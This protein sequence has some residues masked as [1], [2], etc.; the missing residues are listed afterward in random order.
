M[1][2]NTEPEP[3]PDVTQPS[4]TSTPTNGRKALAW[5]SSDTPVKNPFEGAP[6]PDPFDGEDPFGETPKRAIIEVE[7]P[8]P[9]LS[10]Q[11]TNLILKEFLA[12]I[13]TSCLELHPSLVWY[14]PFYIADQDLAQYTREEA[15]EILR[16]VSKLNPEQIQAVIESE[17]DLNIRAL[18][19]TGKTSLL[20]AAISYLL[21]IGIPIDQIAISSHTVS[22]AGEIQSR[23]MPTLETLFPKTYEFYKT[24]SMT[25]GTIHAIAY[26]EM[27][28]HKHPKARW[29]ILDEGHQI[30][31]WKE[32]VLFAYPE[33]A[34]AEIEGP[35]L[36]EL[37]M[38]DRVRGYDIAETQVP[39]VLQLI[40]GSAEL[41]K[42][43]DVYRKIKEAR[44]LL[45]YTDLL[46]E[47]APIIIHPG[48]ANKWR[49]FFVDEFQDTNPL[50]KFLLKL[51]KEQN[52]KLV[53]CGDTRQSI[54]SFTGSD[55]TSHEPFFKE[56]GIKETFLET[57]YR[58]SR[59][60]IGLANAILQSMSPSEEA[61]LRAHAGAPH[62]E[63]A[64]L[65]FTRSYKDNRKFL[66]EK[67]LE[68]MRKKEAEISCNEAIR[69][70]D[71][72]KDEERGQQ[73]VAVLYRTNAQ[74]GVLEEIMSG[75]NSKR[76]AEGKS[77]IPYTRKDFRRTALRN[78]TEREVLMILQ[79]WSDPT[80]C[81]WEDL[82]QTPYFVGIGEVTARTIKRKADQNKPQ[83]LE[84]AAIIFEGELTKRN[85]E[86][87]DTFFQAWEKACDGQ[88]HKEPD[89]EAAAI[90]LEE[91]IL[92]MS[93]KKAATAGSKKEVEDT[94]R[95]SYE[96]G[97][98]ERVKIKQAEGKSLAAIISEISEENE[99]TIANQNNANR[100]LSL[101][102]NN[103]QIVEKE[104]GLVFS[105]IHLAKGR[106]YDGVVIHQMSRGSLPHF[107]ALRFYDN[108]RNEL[109]KRF[110]K[111]ASFPS[112]Q[113]AGENPTSAD[114]P[115][116]RR[117]GVVFS[118][119]RNEID[120]WEDLNN[121]IEE[122]KRLLYV[123]VTRAKKLLSITTADYEYGFL[124]TDV[125]EKLKGNYSFAE[126][127]SKKAG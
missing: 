10:D 89:A 88:T 122:E 37:R 68:I 2:E 22:A 61:R 20:S 72:L 23:V 116:I 84:D 80:Q 5:N 54:N 16:T 66:S 87:M 55:P 105:T 29:T 108:P 92:S 83:C 120:A 93:T 85:V 115:E 114:L 107:N 102:G 15:I 6:S 78:K 124:P 119:P 96:A 30:R 74:G 82:L 104:E 121:P 36:D 126:K 34:G 75:I 32:A 60:V 12:E 58:C 125:W 1:T 94:Q 91:W 17:N 33:K 9:F 11:E 70:Y 112:L 64:N 44:K 48:Y 50:Q 41:P 43:A 123:A 79:A 97:I 45:D 117:F 99:K 63:P 24:S 53:V 7:A 73:T 106:E 14:E 19:G 127:F 52:A 77:A 86:T 28:A 62:G 21:A 65:I 8:I 59:E 76:I 101:M 57:N 98:F 69:L 56:C 49:Y 67:E 4:E 27:I 38:L 31:V 25:A 109:E 81:D 51:L 110:R 103:T 40:G 39:K 95:R 90:A 18:A 118:K 113:V 100:A 71:R 46:R 13:E 3:T 111:Y 35:I 26:R 47:W 42:V